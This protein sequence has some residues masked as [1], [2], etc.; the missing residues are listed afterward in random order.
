MHLETLF[1]LPRE[2]GKEGSPRA[3]EKSKNLVLRV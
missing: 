3:Q 2:E 1:R